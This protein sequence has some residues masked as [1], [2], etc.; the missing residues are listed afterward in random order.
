[1]KIKRLNKDEVKTKNIVLII[2]SILTLI[3]GFSFFFENSIKFLD[4][5][6]IFYV[7]KLLYFGCEFTNYILTRK[8]T[9]MHS[10]YISLACLIASV[11]GLSY[12]NEPT[13]LV[14]T[15]TLI[16]WMIIMVIIKLIRIEDLRNQ[17]NYSVF[18]NLFTMSLFILLG[19]LI[20]TNIYKEITNPCLM[21]GFFFTVNGIL[22][23]IETIGN[24]KFCK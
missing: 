4:G 16:G 18:I 1:M 2:T 3:L 17:N 11:A 19:F 8:L 7:T 13:N 14:L 10:L 5:I 22:N 24:I 15:V 23:L 21:L 20:I 12:M 9:G 6:E